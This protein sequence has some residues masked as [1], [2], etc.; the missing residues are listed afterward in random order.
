MGSL[1]PDHHHLVSTYTNIGDVLCRQNELSDALD[2][3][4]RALNILP[5]HFS[6]TNSDINGISGESDNYTLGSTYFKI[7]DVFR[8]Q[9]KWSDALD[10]YEHALRILL[11]FSSTMNEEI[12][13]ITMDFRTYLITSVYFR[14]GE[15][16]SQQENISDALNSYQNAL[17]TL[18]DSS[19]TIDSVIMKAL[20]KH[21]NIYLNDIYIRIGAL[22]F[23]Q[24][25]FSEA[26]VNYQ[27]ALDIRSNCS[28]PT[29]PAVAK[30]WKS[31]GKVYIGMNNYDRSLF[32]FNTAHAIKHTT[33]S[34]A[35]IDS[36]SQSTIREIYFCKTSV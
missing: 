3:Y 10:N 18:L 13:E 9:E 7:G 24:Q 22:H 1:P 14:I 12:N 31:I 5:K 20:M 19:S 34:S 6:A 25:N 28:S 33:L 4:Q 29:D 23:D 27:H 21:E 15:V 8:L 32:A 11:S 30:I 16:L 35:E 2:S 26:L 36:V 17:N